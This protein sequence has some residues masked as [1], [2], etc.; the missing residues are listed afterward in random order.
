MITPVSGTI[1]REPKNRLTVVV[2]EVAMPEASAV[3]TWDVPWL[4]GQRDAI[5]LWTIA[6][7]SSRLSKPSGS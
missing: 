7:H 4:S 3:T 5:V 2:R 1:I 6:A